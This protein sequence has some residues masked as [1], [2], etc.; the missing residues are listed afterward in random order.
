MIAPMKLPPAAQKLRA[1]ALAHPDT[2]EDF[3]WGHS[4]IKVRGKVFV[5]LGSDEG[6]WTMTVK[7]P[8]SAAAALRLDHVS[9]TGYSLGKSGW[10]TATFPMRGSVDHETLLDW[11]AESY[12]AV[13]L[14]SRAVAKPKGKKAARKS[15]ASGATRKRPVR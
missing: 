5:F 1:A 8:V 9:P 2:H 14:K 15:K 11:L 13:A 7:L 6:T 12:R 3:P 4:A 10:V